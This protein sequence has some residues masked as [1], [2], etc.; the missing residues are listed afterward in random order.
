[1]A[2]GEESLFET[3]KEKSSSLQRLIIIFLGV[4]FFFF[5]MILIPYYSLKV[6]T[7]TLFNI[8]GLLNKT[9]DDIK[10]AADALTNQY[11]K[12][13]EQNRNLTK[14]I[15]AYGNQLLNQSLN[16]NNLT[17]ITYRNCDAYVKRS[18][19]W[20]NCN[21][22]IRLEELQ[23][24]L[25]ATIRL[26]NT[27]IRH[28]NDA[29]SRQINLI[30][31]SKNFLDINKIGT[32]KAALE[33]LTSG[34]SVQILYGLQPTVI[35]LTQG[36]NKQISNLLI[37]M[38]ALSERFKSLDTPLGGNIPVSFNEMLAVFPLA[39]SIVF[40]YF[41]LMLRDT[42][43]LRRVIANNPA[44]QK[45]REYISKSPLWIDPLWIDPKLS[46]DNTGRILHAILAWTVLAIPAL[47]FIASVIM[48]SF[49]WFWISIESDRFPA[50]VAAAEFNKLVYGMLY[51]IS[52]IL[53]GFCYT[54]II[55]EVR[56]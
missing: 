11:S 33:N 18:Q 23:G 13:L 24:Q 27:T 30:E 31:E 39:L 6:D 53:L 37:Q 54:L 36:V 29:I 47:L 7:H 48:I 2:K 1:M 5:F 28:I 50:F 17:K 43:R 19:P 21:S 42:I 44:D 14:G 3:Y 35:N 25:N 49:I 52:G 45:I 22:D 9:K 51:I 26:N 20:I 16:S 56:T 38:N 15:D 12:N 8:F 34:R 4:V 41:A 46:D 55:K 32:V 10:Y 40:C